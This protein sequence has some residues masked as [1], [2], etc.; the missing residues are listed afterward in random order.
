MQVLYKY[1]VV[2]W[3]V[4]TYVHRYLENDEKC[5]QYK[6]NKIK[7]WRKHFK[8]YDKHWKVKNVNQNNI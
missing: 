2:T 6:L 1:F 8:L 7:Y 3:F 4:I 5:N